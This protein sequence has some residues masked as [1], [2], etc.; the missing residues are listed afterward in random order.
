MHTK[1]GLTPKMTRALSGCAALMLCAGASAQT[2]VSGALDF[3]GNGRH[4]SE[5]IQLG[6]GFDC[7]HNALL[8]TADVMMPHFT[9]ALEQINAVEQFQ[10][11]VWDAR[12]IDFNQDGLDDL[13]VIAMTS[14]NLGGITLWRNAGGAGLEYVT[15]I[16]M[17]N[18]RPT[19]L[20]VGDLNNDGMQDFVA[21]D[22]S[23]NQAYV[24]LATGPETFSAPQTL[25]GQPANNGSTGI[26]LGDLDQDGD[27]DV[28]FSTWYPG[29]I[30]TY[31]NDG[32]GNFTA[33]AW[34]TTD[35]EPRDVSIADIN[36]DGFPDIAAACEHWSGPFD[37][38]TAVIHTNNG[39]GTYSWTHTITMPAGGP[40][41]N[42]RAEARF[43]ELRDINN[44][45]T[46]DL[47]TSSS[48]SNIVT[49]HTNDGAGNFTLSQSFGGWW[50]ESEARDVKLV[51]FDLDGW[52]DMVWGDVDMHKVAIYRNN[53]GV[54][55]FHQNFA[56][57][58][59]GGFSVAAGDFSG[60]GLPDIVATND[61]SRT[62][63]ILVNKGAFNFDAAIQLRPSEYPASSQL[64]DFTGD[65][66]TDLFSI[67][68][69]YISGDSFL[70]VYEGL[71]DAV[72]SKEPIETLLTT[73]IGYILVRDVNEDGTPD[74]LSVTGPCKVFPGNGDGT[75]GT[76]IESPITPFGLRI[77]TGD[78]NLDGHMDIAWVAGGHPSLLRVSFGD[79]TGAF[80]AYTEYTD[81][82]EDESVG[83]G[84]ING[85]GA[86]EIFTGHRYGIF[87]IH[88]NNGDGTFG[89]RRDIY[90]PG[91]SIDPA[92][93]AIAI[94]DFDGD[95]HNDVVVSGFGLMMFLNPL[96]DGNLPETP[97]QVSQYG[98]S[99]LTPTDVDLDGDIDLYARS[100]SGAVFY[101]PGDGVF[102]DPMFLPRYDSNARSMVVA[103]A[104]NDGRQ[105]I[106]VG[107][108]NSWSQYLFLN[109]PSMEA[110]A[111]ANMVPDSCEAPVTCPGDVSGPNGVAD[112]RVNV[113]D[114]NAILS[115]WGLSVHPGAPED[116]A[117]D[118]GMIDVDDLNVVLINWQTTC[119]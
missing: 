101:N 41:Y 92:F 115:L 68:Q 44:D 1:N 119:N 78:I 109:L 118:D 96:G 5:D 60:D 12:P 26:D 17:P 3:N 48:V 85:D 57:G 89:T 99:I 47:I 14:T 76:A 111:N 104:N 116:L 91:T 71:G 66:I 100:A 62:F 28:V 88:P 108:E 29:M 58:N 16:N 34:F 22:S 56:S 84:D 50:L 43:L 55:E 114:L 80:G 42:N 52:L 40:P 39:D 19:V 63:S 38:G 106:M 25:P 32:K 73:S 82:K 65:G 24:F 94:A 15:R 117:G 46:N 107:P 86:P 95:T 18:A 54:F 2:T 87:S 75:F 79:G 23:Y 53:A 103:D 45:G 74:L 37:D 97:V 113:D 7:N 35:R 13:V 10:N 4:D 49:I 90:V 64:A 33:G 83:I 27:L 70:S 36:G 61:A 102:G 67:R 59:Y 81:V 31:I 77:V 20:Q 112:G 110:D 72:F 8:D 30:N 98:A 51:D 21:S 105:D 93:G 6:I 9:V 69:P 11:N